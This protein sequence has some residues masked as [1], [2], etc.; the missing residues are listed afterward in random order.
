MLATVTAATIPVV[1][2]AVIAAWAALKARR[3]T[4]GSIGLIDVSVTDAERVLAEPGSDAQLL[5]DI[6]Q[7]RPVLDVVVRNDGESKAL[8]RRVHLEVDGLLHVP[9]VDPP[10]VFRLPGLDITERLPVRERRLGPSASYTVRFPLR[11]GRFAHVVNH[12]VAPG[13]V[14]R[15]LVP[16][17]AQEARRGQDFYEVRLFLDSGKG[18]K[19]R[20]RAA[21][22][23]LRVVAHG[24]PSWERPE[25][26]RERLNHIA[27][28]VREEAQA[29]G[30]DVGVL[31]NSAL[32]PVRTGM[33]DY[34]AFYESKLSILRAALGECLKHAADETRIRGWITE[35]EQAS[36]GIEG[37]HRHAVS[38]RDSGRHP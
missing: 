22:R 14:E 15:F 24:E 1:A 4:E 17:V 33:E 3:K 12:E 27:D 21:S 5:G 35:L 2:G 38:L 37:L 23:P 8:V 20:R 34:I 29:G 6:V 30:E 26:I 31:F 9:A 7:D 18:R 19:N 16:L 32:H 10:G 28:R 36:A 25:E 11:E 13:D